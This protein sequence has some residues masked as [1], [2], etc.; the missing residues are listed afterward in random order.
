LR[1]VRAGTISGCAARTRHQKAYRK[2]PVMYRVLPMIICVVGVLF[3]GCV[4]DMADV[5][6]AHERGEGSTKT[7]PVDYDTAWK[8]AIQVFRWG[9]GGAI[10]EHKDE[11]YMLTMH[12]GNL[13]TMG[14]VMGAW[15]KR[16]SSEETEVTV[17]TKRR[18]ATNLATGLT[19][20]TYH[21]W[22]AE[23]VRLTKAG[24]PLPRRAPDIDAEQ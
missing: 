1:D 20:S 22:F 3:S 15:L 19:E 7:Y 4:R 23:G 16:L 24:K 12:S 18:M 11:G 2:G 9:G 6:D 5:I 10:E 13:V 17:V 21:R 14:S 8:I